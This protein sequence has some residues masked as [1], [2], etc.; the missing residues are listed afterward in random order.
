MFLFSLMSYRLTTFLRQLPLISVL[1]PLLDCYRPP[2]YLQ[3]PQSCQ[4]QE[5]VR[6][7]KRRQLPGHTCDQ[8]DHVSVLSQTVCFF[9]NVP[10]FSISLFLGSPFQYYKVAGLNVEDV[11]KCSRHRAWQKRPPTPKGVLNRQQL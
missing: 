5:S 1:L 4:I 2:N 6:G 8:C 9:L 3:P 10:L 7:A 11:Q